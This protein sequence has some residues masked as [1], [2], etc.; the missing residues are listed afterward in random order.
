MRW[1]PLGKRAVQL[2]AV[3]LGLEL[4]YVVAVNL[5]LLSGLIE[6]AASA[7]PDEAQLSWRRAF[8]PWPGRVWVEGLQL[9]VQDPGLQFQLDVA[10]A[11]VDVVLWT[12]LKKEFRASRV[13][14][15][16]V[17]YRM[18]G[19]VEPETAGSARVRAFPPIV[20]LSRPPLR[21][22]PMPPLPTGAKLDAIWG[23]RLSDVEGVVEELWIQEFR[24]LGPA[25]VSGGFHLSPLRALEVGPASLVL[26]GGVLGAG[27]RVVSAPVFASAV[28]TIAPVDLAA[29]PGLGFLEG[30]SVTARLELPLGNLGLAD[31]YQDAVRLHGRG[32]LSARV[33]VS[34]GHLGSATVASLSLPGLEATMAGYRFVGDVEAGLE[35]PEG[36]AGARGQLTVSGTASGAVPGGG[37][38]TASLTGGTAALALGDREL[39]RAFTLSWLSVGLGQARVVDARNITERVAVAVPLIAPIVLGGG[40][41]VASGTAYVTPAYAL[42]R[43]KEARLGDA[44]LGGA[45]L[46]GAVGWTGAVAGHFGLVRL[47]L[48]LR[49]GKLESVVGAPP[50]WLDAEL[51]GAGIKPD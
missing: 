24:Y 19:R 15:E 1:R 34:D 8:T 33:V 29:S 23:V 46:K 39:T 47:G 9:R 38:V 49:D 6:R 20:G 5:L 10:R 17:R 43:L 16:G 40:P 32:H 26:E 7:N 37:Q 48:R 12:L 25:H 11:E 44:A 51:V 3:L 35:L 28:V 41:L 14:A 31:L 30:L 18:L 42:V 36:A 50:S 45:A 22:V 2:G 13:R 21:P 27:D 4:L